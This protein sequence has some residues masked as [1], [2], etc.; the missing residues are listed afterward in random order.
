MK[1][2]FLHSKKS[3]KEILLEVYDEYQWYIDYDFPIVLPKFF[4]EL[5]NKKKDN[6]K[7]FA[8]KLGNQLDRI[9]DKDIYQRKIIA[10]QK[11][12]R[13]KEEKFFQIMEAF[14]FKPKEKY[15]CHTTLY[16]PQ[17]QFKYPD[18]FSVRMSTAQDAKDSNTTIAHEL[19][20]LLIFNKVKKLKLNYEKTEGIVDLFF[21]KTEL[22]KLFPYHGL[23]TTAIHD[24]KIF[25]KLCQ[26]QQYN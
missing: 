3:E 16:G 22:K 7:T 10:A 9:Y 20:H 4:K 14:G 18:S 11:S 2:Q 5:Y 23:Q 15:Y 25:K 24:A 17:G 1:I 19:V 26:T 13:K 6:K 21:T 12:W 8:K